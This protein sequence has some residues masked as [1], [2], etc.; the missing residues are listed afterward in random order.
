[1]I[2]KFLIVIMIILI[3]IIFDFGKNLDICIVYDYV[4]F[5]ENFYLILWYLKYL[6]WIKYIKILFSYK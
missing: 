2:V 4:I 1:M 6:K 3:C 5:I